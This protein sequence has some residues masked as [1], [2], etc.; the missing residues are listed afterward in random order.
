MLWETDNRHQQK[1]DLKHNSIN[2]E[3]SSLA[4]TNE[5]IFWKPGPKHNL[6]TQ[7]V[8]TDSGSEL[9]LG[10]LREIRGRSLI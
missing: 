6:A 3:P 1:A 4:D 7:P 5:T 10:L 2:K 9:K 8:D